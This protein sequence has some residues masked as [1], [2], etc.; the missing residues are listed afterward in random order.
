MKI[1]EAQKIAYEQRLIASLA[2]CTTLEQ[3]AYT[4]S[5]EF[6]YEGLQVDDQITIVSWLGRG[7]NAKIHQIRALCIQS[8]ESIFDQMTFDDVFL[9]SRMILSVVEHA[10]RPGY[11]D[12][13][14][15]PT[16]K[17]HY[18]DSVANECR[19]IYHC[20]LGERHPNREAFDI[21]RI[22]LV[23]WRLNRVNWLLHVS[24]KYAISQ[25]LLRNAKTFG[26]CRRISRYLHAGRIGREIFRKMYH[27]AKTTDEYFTVACIAKKR[28]ENSLWEKYV[29]RCARA[30]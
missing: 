20:F 11:G 30:I 23:G 15:E 29:K 14:T 26:D 27:L 24:E 10:W 13:A 21:Q 16:K 9:A 5:R 6:A 17:L 4:V 25:L 2:K 12:V 7:E 19:Y 8:L 22:K 3:W 1:T 18:Y 28:D